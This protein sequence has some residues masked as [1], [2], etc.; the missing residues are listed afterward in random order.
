MGRKGLGGGKRGA[1]GLGVACAL[2]DFGS[3]REDN[4]NAFRIGNRAQQRLTD[5]EATSRI[6]EARAPGMTI[7]IVVVARLAASDACVTDAT[8]TSGVS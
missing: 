1:S 5:I 8:M 4:A 3:N 2:L 7:G 6:G